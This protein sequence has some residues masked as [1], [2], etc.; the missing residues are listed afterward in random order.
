MINETKNIQGADWEG[1]YNLKETKYEGGTEG[2]LEEI[3]KGLPRCPV[4]GGEARIVLFGGGEEK[5]GIWIGCDRTH[6]CVRNI[7]YHPWGWS[8][9]ESVQEWEKYNKGVLGAIRKAKIWFEKRYGV[10]TKGIKK[11]EKEVEEKEKAKIEFK[12]RVFEGIEK[13]KGEEKTK[14]GAET[15]E[16]TFVGKE[17]VKVEGKVEGGKT[18]PKGKWDESKNW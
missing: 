14:E 13:S 6:K 18:S 15:G 9:E 16:E 11:Y 12:K 7:V 2:A 3:A 10:V 1:K 8:I 5:S 4:C 17:E